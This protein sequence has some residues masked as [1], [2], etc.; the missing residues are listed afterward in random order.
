MSTAEPIPPNTNAEQQVQQPRRPRQRHCGHCGVAGHDRRTCP[1][2]EQV[3]RRRLSRERLHAAFLQSRGGANRNRIQQDAQT[4]QTD[5]RISYKL[6]NNNNYD[7][8]I[9]W[10]D[11][12]ETTVKYLQTLRRFS[13]KTILAIPT[14]RFVFIPRLEFNR[15]DVPHTSD[16]LDM[17]ST[18]KFIVGDYNLIDFENHEINIIKEYTIPKPPLDQ[19]KECGLKSLFLLKELERMGAKKYDNLEPIMDMVQDI[20]IPEHTEHDKESAGVPST[21]TNLT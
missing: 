17:N 4:Q 12:G 14:H 5:N 8:R 7:V 2:P 3:E 9:Y 6:F 18:D 1:A 20:K 13:E 16:R 15:L 10:S 11:I 21:F 19:W